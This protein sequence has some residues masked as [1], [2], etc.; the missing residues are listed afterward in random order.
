M[1][2]STFRRLISAAAL[3]A[4][5]LVAPSAIAGPF[6]SMFIFGDSLSD[7]GNLHIAS[8]GLFPDLSKGP[9]FNGRYS[10]G[11][12]WVERLATDLGLSGQANPYLAGG[13]NFAFA[14]ARTGT[15]SNPPGVLAQVV[16]IWNGIG[17]P[18]ALYIV[19]GGGNDMR[20]A[21]SAFTGNSAADMAG[22]E[23]AAEAAVGNL[24][25][26]LGFL[27]L[28]GAKHVLISDL[29]D[30]GKSPEAV[31]LGLQ[32][33][34]TDATNRFNALMPSLLAT[35][36]GFGLDMSFLD[37]AGL[38]EA[39]ITD[40]T[41]NGSAKYGIT[42]ITHPCAG[43][44]FST[45]VSCSVSLFSDVLHPSAAAHRLIGDAAFAAAVPEPETYALFAFG[46]VALA[47]RRL[48]QRR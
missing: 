39:V 22:R 28:H 27:A 20:D 5:A 16:G 25:S 8:G 34:S 32:A 12:L 42:D 24:A 43:F 10:D 18:N 19:V 26:S 3:A 29:P 31:L 40:T 1:N 37:M 36:A 47:L 41:S 14:G 33:P 6:S 30:L 9:Y 35:G 2:R 4:S 38:L 13:N 48:R 11:P 17:D 7:T 46:L 45:G 44:E 15:G 21:R 23:L